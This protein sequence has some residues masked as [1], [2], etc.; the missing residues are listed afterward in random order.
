MALVV[1]VVV[2]VRAAKQFLVVV[3]CVSGMVIVGWWPWPWGGGCGV[4]VGR[5]WCKVVFIS[6][7][8]VVKESLGM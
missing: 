3:G 4:V 2:V 8:I 7:L 6:K 1:I 5:C